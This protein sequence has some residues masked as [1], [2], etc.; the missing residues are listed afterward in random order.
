MNDQRKSE[1]PWGKVVLGCFGIGCLGLL[2]L[3][4]VGFY[5]LKDAVSVTPEGAAKIQ[6]SIL[7]GSELPEGYTPQMGVSLGGVDMVVIE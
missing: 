5:F 4:G 6:R 3:G 2:V 7:P 1:T